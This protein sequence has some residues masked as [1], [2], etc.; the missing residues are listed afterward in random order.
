VNC[1][2]RPSFLHSSFI[3]PVLHCKTNGNRFFL[4]LNGK[5]FFRGT[6]RL[7][8]R[9]NK[10]PLRIYA[11]LPLLSLSLCVKYGLL[12]RDGLKNGL[13]ISIMKKINGE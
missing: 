9:H 11:H 12:R 7:F 10:E 5:R 1:H 13:K 6:K 8:T 2:L 4:P 3:L